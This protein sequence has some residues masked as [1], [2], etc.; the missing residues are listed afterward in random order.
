MTGRQIAVVEWVLA[1]LLL[2]WFALFLIAQQN[3]LALG[4]VISSVFF[5]P[6]I[7]LSLALNGLV[8][9]L[10]RDVRLGMSEHILLGIEGLIIVLLIAAS[11]YD[12]VNYGPTSGVGSGFGHWL[13]WFLPLWV[14]VGPIALAILIVGLVRRRPAAPIAPVAA[15]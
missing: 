11:V 8:H 2:V 9:F 13:E 12:Q 10:R 6:G 5:A 1:G 4:L 3:S 7:A 14:L 15:P